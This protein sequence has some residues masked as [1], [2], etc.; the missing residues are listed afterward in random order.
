MAVEEENAIR[1]ASGYVVEVLK[2]RYEKKG[3]IT[4]SHCLMSMKEGMKGYSGDEEGGSFLGYTHVWLD[5]INRGEL[6]RVSDDV[7]KF[8]LELELCMYPMLRNRLDASGSDQSKDAMLHLIQNDEDVLFAVSSV[9]IYLS[10]S[11]SHLLLKDVIRL[12][13]NIRGF[14]IASKLVEDFKVAT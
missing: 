7:Y 4:I 6:F 3:P 1:Y 5:L 12:W 11:G 13:T 2:K 8:L 9:S 10:E 14:S